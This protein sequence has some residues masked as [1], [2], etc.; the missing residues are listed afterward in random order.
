MPTNRRV[1]STI[2][3]FVVI[4]V[5][6]TAAKA[7]ALRNPAV[8][9]LDAL[10][11]AAG[12]AETNGDMR[13]AD[14]TYALAIRHYRAHAKTWAA[15][16]EHLRF[17]VHDDVG[18]VA[19]FNQAINAARP[20]PQALAFAWRGLGELEA[21]KGNE[22]AAVE[23][24]EK[25]LKAMPLSDTHR[26]LCHLYVQRRDWKNAAEHARAAAE[27]DADDPI[28]ALLYAAQLH[29]AG[30]SAK[31]RGEFERAMSLAGIDAGGNPSRP[32]HCCVWYNAAG[33]HAVCGQN[34]EALK[35][36]DSFFQTPNHR[37]LTR[38]QIEEDPDFAEL[39]KEPEFSEM[40]DHY[41]TDLS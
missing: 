34:A 10:L 29:R 35:M 36:L 17:Y 7:V 3:V 8:P 15:Y 1:H 40:L 24:F 2:A 13:A 26:S 16:G 32:V 23:L 37:H 19:A 25:S 22:D 14:E 30:E 28:A 33:Y 6:A 20:D 18:A 21:K 11:D 38:K 27:A 31:A 39:K 5:L 12:V 4:A 41:A 9:K